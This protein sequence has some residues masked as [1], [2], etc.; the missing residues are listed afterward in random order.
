VTYAEG[1]SSGGVGSGHSQR[2]GRVVGVGTADLRHDEVH[3][4]LTEYLEGTLDEAQAARVRGHLRDCAAC[5]ADL[6]TLENTID[7]LHGLPSHTASDALRQRLLAIP[8]AEQ[9][10]QQGP[11]GS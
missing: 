7:I 9:A 5:A 11:N 1:P 4:Q 6:R 8:D 2:T 10:A 3:N